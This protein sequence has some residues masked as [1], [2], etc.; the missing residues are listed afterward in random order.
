MLDDLRYRALVSAVVKA[1]RL[2]D[3]LA[4]AGEK[5]C[6]ALHARLMRK[7]LACGSWELM[8]TVEELDGETRRRIDCQCGLTWFDPV[9]AKNIT[10]EKWRK[11]GL[12]RL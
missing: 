7:C 4:A 12:M 1:R 11:K 8:T 9:E 5:V 3:A 6:R 2:N 10:E